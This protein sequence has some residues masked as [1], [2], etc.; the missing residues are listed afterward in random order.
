MLPVIHSYTDIC[1]PTVTT[2]RCNYHGVVHA[3]RQDLADSCSACKTC[4]QS[5]RKCMREIDSMTKALVT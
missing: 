5:L 4:A 2:V 1:W 3:D